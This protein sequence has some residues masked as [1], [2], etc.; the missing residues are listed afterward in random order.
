LTTTTAN[1]YAHRRSLLRTAA[2]LSLLA[3]VLAIVY[4]IFVV[5]ATESAVVTRF[6]RVVRVIA[7]PGLYFTLPFDSVARVDKRILL[8]RPARSEYLTTDK[9][10]VVVESLASW[11]IA[12]PQRFLSSFPTVASAQLH[13]ADII[14][15]EI[16]SV[17][18]R[19]PA[20]ALIATDP[21][22]THYQAIVAEISQGVAA[23]AKSAYGI[24]VFSVDL[25]HL[26]LPEQNR[27]HVFDRMQA[28]R[29]KMAK[30]NRSA[31]ELEA[32]K[33]LAQAESEKSHLEAEAALTAERLKAEGDAE[34]ARIYAAAFQQDPKFYYFL[35]SLRAYDKFLDDKTTVFLPADAEV[36]RMLRFDVQPAPVE[37]PASRGVIG[38]APSGPGF[39]AG[40]DVLMPNKSRGEVR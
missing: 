23:F 7:E 12:D 25:A 4:G 6:G 1:G 28:E 14:L 29:A 31:G 38:N 33:I 5:D 34:A 19:Y 22:L 16:G 10:N 40:S 30:E 27:D 20:S 39:S 36:L 37:N 13:L 9:K 8:S 24:E 32:K 11:R 15:A 18:G 35:R 26:S 2:L 21:S 3:A 17:I